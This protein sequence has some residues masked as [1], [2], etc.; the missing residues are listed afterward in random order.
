MRPNWRVE[1]LQNRLSLDR[2]RF[3]P[4]HADEIPEMLIA[5]N[6]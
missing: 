1:E 2:F 6:E 4:L 5:R 3:T